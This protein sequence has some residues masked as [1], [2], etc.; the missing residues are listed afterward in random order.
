MSPRIRDAGPEGDTSDVTNHVVRTATDP[1]ANA[2]DK[3][4]WLDC[5]LTVEGP[6]IPGGIG[7][8]LWITPTKE[9][10]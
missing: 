7:D 10:R 6:A 1:R 2:D 5:N 4:E 8:V 3:F 9:T